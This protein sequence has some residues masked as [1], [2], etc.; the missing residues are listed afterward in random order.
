ME[1]NFLYNFIPTFCFIEL[2]LC[3]GMSLVGAENM[4]E[5]NFDVVQE[6]FL[7]NSIW[8]VYRSIF[9]F[10]ILSVHIEKNIMDKTCIFPKVVGDFHRCL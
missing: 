1:M 6:T 2:L 5:E 3:G 9:L 7:E 10:Q 8:D 4:F